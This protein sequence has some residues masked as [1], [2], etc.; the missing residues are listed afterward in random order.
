M[1]AEL[2][3]SWRAP[4]AA[5]SEEQRSVEPGIE[6]GIEASIEAESWWDPHTRVSGA[7]EV[8]ASPTKASGEAEMA[9]PPDPAW[10]PVPG[11]HAARRRWS[12]GLRVPEPLR[13]RLALTP[14][15]LT[16]IAVGV[17]AALAVTCW[18]VIRSD[19]RPGPVPTLASATPL[20][21]LSTGPVSST[22]PDGSAT[23][24]A[25]M[26]SSASVGTVTVDIEGKVRRPGIVVLPTGSRVV[27][28]IK[29]A[30]GASRRRD[31]A[32][33]NLAAVLADGQQFVV[34]AGSGPAPGGSVPSGAPP[35]MTG[36]LVN[37]NSATLEQ[38][39]TLPGVGPVTAQSILDWRTKN[40]GFSSVDELLEV[41]GIGPA[42]LQK[43]TP[44]VTV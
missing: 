41:D 8:A 30:G 29:A 5:A 15:H 28:A 24:A 43:L 21:A 39:D 11:R 12:V 31:L 35:S 37:L 16:L 38:L 19:P 10:V 42:T 25:E 23:S 18:W 26:T 32:G 2:A 1:R 6:A 27:D 14:W 36:A 4:Q 13:G 17:A 9:T 44:L 40:G 3:S 33:L 7:G 34:G 22:G 20:T